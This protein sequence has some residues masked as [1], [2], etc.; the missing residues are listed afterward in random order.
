[1]LFLARQQHSS[2]PCLTFFDKQDAIP[3]LPEAPFAR[4]LPDAQDVAMH[5]FARLGTRHA[6][7]DNHDLFPQSRPVWLILE[8][9]P[10]MAFL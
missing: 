9:R 6:W 2:R 4:N 5:R 1:M 7:Q 8:I 10:L 3:S